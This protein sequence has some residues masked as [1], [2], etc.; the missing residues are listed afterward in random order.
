MRLGGMGMG[1]SGMGMGLQCTMWLFSIT[2]VYRGS[3]PSH[4]HTITNYTTFQARVRACASCHANGRSEQ[5]FSGFSPVATCNCLAPPTTEESTVS[6]SNDSSNNI[7]KTI[8]VSPNQ[9]NQVAKSQNW[10]L[11]VMFV[12]VSISVVVIAILLGKLFVASSP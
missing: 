2:Q 1:L 5:L 4:T 10:L 7:P 8:G 12:G 3:T 11:L 9:Q 6:T